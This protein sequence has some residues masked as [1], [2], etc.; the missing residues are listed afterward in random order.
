MGPEIKKGPLAA[1]PWGLGETWD[2]ILSTYAS[3]SS[4]IIGTVSVEELRGPI[5]I[6]SIAIK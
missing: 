1:L 3:F 5:G 2:L 6:G 4:L